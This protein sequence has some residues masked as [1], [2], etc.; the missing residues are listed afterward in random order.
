MVLHAALTSAM[1]LMEAVV[2]SLIDAFGWSRGKATL[3]ETVISAVMGVIICLGYNAF[4]FEAKL[5]NGSSAQ[6][7]DILDYVSNNI[8][9]PF[10]AICTCVLIGWIVKPNLLVGEMRL[11]G[12]KFRRKT[13]YVVMLKYVVPIMLI[14]LLL[15]CFGLY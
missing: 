9:M 6:I 11:N 8:L 13:L 5:P 7:L 15:G 3:I 10:L 14:V 12:Y 2:A 4:Y 1:S